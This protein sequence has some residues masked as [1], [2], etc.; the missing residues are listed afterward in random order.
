[1]RVDL[2]NL[3]GKGKEAEK[4]ARDLQVTIEELGAGELDQWAFHRKLADSFRVQKR[5]AEALVEGTK[6]LEIANK[7]KLRPDLIALDEILVAQIESKL[8][9]REQAIKR[10]KAALELFKTYKGQPRAEREAQKI[11]AH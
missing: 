3:D 10:A 5:Y 6:A 2:L 7:Q 4:L 9:K 8:G 11:L 1:W